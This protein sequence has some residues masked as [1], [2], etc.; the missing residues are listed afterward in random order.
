MYRAIHNTKVPL[1]ISIVSMFTNVCLNYVL[2]FGKF[3]FPMLGVG[4]AAYA[5]LIAQ[6]LGLTIHIIFAVRTYQPFMGRAR[7]LFGFDLNFVKPVMKKIF[8]LI[9]NELMFGFGNTLFI[10]AFG[11][12]GTKS[13]EAYYVGNKISE[14]FF[15]VVM[16][17]SN[18]TAVMLGN[19]LGSG[20]IEKA[21]QEGNYFVGTAGILAVISTVLIIVFAR[22]MVSVFGLKDPAVFLNAVTIVRVFS[23]KI[24]VR[25]FV[26][27]VF[28]SLR[29]GGDSKTLT[30][31]DSGIMWL[32]GLPLAFFA[33]SVLKIQEIWMVFLFIQ[34]EQ[35][36]R[37]TLGLI[38]YKSG[39]WAVN[40]TKSV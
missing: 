10:K 6:C 33:V 17:V 3:G 39:K 29:A 35:V 25:L 36:I 5:T 21:K 12:L 9:F 8:P 23:V 1:F 11:A 4:G 13:M 15:F 30:Y 40:L 37:V 22:P 16:G 19:T 26:V 32:V 7:E 31:L 2:I 18:A 24:S 38:R 27:I 28:A 20:D 34:L 14:I